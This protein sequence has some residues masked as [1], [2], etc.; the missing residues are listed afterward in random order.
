M[1]NFWIL[2]DLTLI[3]YETE[4]DLTWSRNCIISETSIT[5]D[6]PANPDTNPPVQTFQIDK[7]ERYVPVITINDNIKFLEQ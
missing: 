1:T 5:P 2:L 3:H 6:I 7:A 4:L